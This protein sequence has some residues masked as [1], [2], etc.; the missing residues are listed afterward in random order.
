[1]EDDIICKTDNRPNNNF[2][3]EQIPIALEVFSVYLVASGTPL[4]AEMPLDQKEVY[5]IEVRSNV[6]HQ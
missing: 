4:L 2:V 6:H 3:N 1:M 5:K